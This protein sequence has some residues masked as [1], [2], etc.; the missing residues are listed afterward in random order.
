[1]AHN[2]TSLACMDTFLLLLTTLAMI[3]RWR[4]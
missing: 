4:A 1:M 2:I 3:D